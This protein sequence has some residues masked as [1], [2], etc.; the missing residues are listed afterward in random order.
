M[1]PGRRYNPSIMSLINYI[2]KEEGQ[3]RGV[4]RRYLGCR[5]KKRKVLRESASTRP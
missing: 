4:G 1:I 2:Y 3:G 5:I